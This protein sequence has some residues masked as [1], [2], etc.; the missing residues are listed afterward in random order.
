MISKKERKELNKTWRE[1]NPDK[2]EEYKLKYKLK[3]KEEEVENADE[4]FYKTKY[5][6]KR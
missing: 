6:E 4:L 2:L 5:I 1:K 3:K